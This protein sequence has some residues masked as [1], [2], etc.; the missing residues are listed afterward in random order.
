MPQILVVVAVGLNAIIPPSIKTS[1]RASNASATSCKVLV[2]HKLIVV[3]TTPYKL[4]HTHMS[5]SS[6]VLRSIEVALAPAAH[7]VKS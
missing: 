7:F 3:I 2:P 6:P 4:L 5:N 1:P